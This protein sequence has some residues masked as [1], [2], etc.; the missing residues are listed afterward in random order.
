LL[1]R[2]QQ[3]NEAQR[4]DAER[5]KLRLRANAAGLERE[6]GRKLVAELLFDGVEGVYIGHV[7]GVL[8][9]TDLVTSSIFA[10]RGWDDGLKV[11]ALS[12]ANDRGPSGRF[13]A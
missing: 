10:A 7:R 13:K 4:I 9:C 8:H 11:A 2:Q 3:R 12:I 5:L 6:Q 1:D